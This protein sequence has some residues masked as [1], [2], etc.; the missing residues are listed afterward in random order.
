MKKNHNVRND[1][2]THVR[3]VTL[4]GDFRVSKRYPIEFETQLTDSK[5]KADF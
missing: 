4:R 3:N 2:L 5:E 1:T